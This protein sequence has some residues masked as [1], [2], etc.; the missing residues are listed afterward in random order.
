MHKLK[1]LT[2]KF[3]TLKKLEKNIIHNTLHEREKLKENAKNKML[4]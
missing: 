4:T 1:I 2:R 3:S